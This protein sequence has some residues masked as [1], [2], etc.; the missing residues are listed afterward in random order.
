MSRPLYFDDGVLEV[1]TESETAVAIAGLQGLTITPSWNI[2]RYYTADS[3]FIESQ[4]QSEHEVPVE[5]DYGKF[6]VEAAQEWLGGDG[7]TATSSTDTSD[8]QKYTVS[9]VTEADDG[10]FERTCVVEGVTFEEFPMVDGSRGEFEEFNLSGT[11]EIISQLEDT[12]A[13]E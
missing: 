4:K 6:D 12:S 10:S 13:A 5:I 9:A 3:G 2:N 7:S 1:E 11:G 8:P